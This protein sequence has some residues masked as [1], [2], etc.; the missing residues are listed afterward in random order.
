VDIVAAQGNGGQ[1]IVLVPSL[2]LVVVLT[3]GAYNSQSPSNAVLAEVLLPP[4]LAG[5]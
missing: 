1:K 2:D 4:L 5:K 3:A